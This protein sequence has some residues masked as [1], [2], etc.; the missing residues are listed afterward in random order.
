MQIS[1]RG[2]AL[3]TAAAAVSVPFLG[4]TQAVAAT[5]RSGVRYY[6]VVYEVTDG[7]SVETNWS[8]DRMRVDML[9]IAT[10]LRANSVLIEGDGVERLTRTANEAA[11]RGLD[12]WLRPTLGDVPAADILD[13]LAETGKAAE[14]LR[15]QGATVHL[16]VGCEFVLYVPGIVPGAD[17]VE[18]VQN[19]LNGNYD[20]VQMERRL[21]AFTARAAATG[22]KVFRGGLTYSAAQD[23][24]VDWTL[25][26]IVGID[27]YSYFQH[28]AQYVAE[29]RK[30]QKWGKPVAITEFG[31]CTY[32]GAQREA[33]MGWDKVDYTKNPEQIKGHLVRS[34]ATQAE[35][36]DTLLDVF[37][38][39]GLY[40]AMTYNFV[41]PDAPHR[42]QPKYDLDMASYSIVKTRWESFDKPGQHWHWQPKQAFNTLAR[43][44]R[45]KERR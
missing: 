42:T 1:R 4:A 20:P 39:M 12:V 8:V 41:N 2:F 44:Y 23:E 9:A 43:H 13:H 27:Y 31:C 36:L 11:E 14:R 35:Y 32:R 6:G 33:D 30:F 38:S 21:H 15:R 24:D 3:G 18:R 22:R 34:E 19:L 5:R 29:L 16:S 28:R 37:D 45:A 26:D 7:G 10:W 25:F 40:A 17:A